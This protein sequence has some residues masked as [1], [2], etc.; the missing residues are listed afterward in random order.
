MSVLLLGIIHLLARCLLSTS[1]VV[2]PAAHVA[3]CVHGAALS[4]CLVII[5]AN[6]DGR[7]ACFK[8]VVYSMNLITYGEKSGLWAAL[9]RARLNDGV[10]G[11]AGTISGLFGM[12]DTWT[13]SVV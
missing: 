1:G 11:V 3:G 4:N 6:V 10:M 7:G 8:L 5:L 9:F 13:K 2:S 12:R